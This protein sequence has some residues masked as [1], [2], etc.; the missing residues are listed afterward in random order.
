V[1]EP[2]DAVA[3]DDRQEARIV[4]DF[5]GVLD[6]LAGQSRGRDEHA[7][8]RIHL[9]HPRRHLWRTG[10]GHHQAGGLQL[11]PWMA[12]VTLQRS[13][14][15]REFPRARGQRNERYTWPTL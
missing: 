1:A 12:H 4:R 9:P 3:R 11:K 15:N 6:P 14:K 5:P 8:E 2:F 13:R 10:I 7:A